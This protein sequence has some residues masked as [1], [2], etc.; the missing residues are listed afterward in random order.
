MKQNTATIRRHSEAIQKDEL[1]SAWL[2]LIRLCRELGHGEIERIRI[3]DG[4]P[5]LIEVTRQKIK[6]T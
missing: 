1:H 4:L 6:L 5:M 3:Q 2:T